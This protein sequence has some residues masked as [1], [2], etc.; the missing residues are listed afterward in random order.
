MEPR[1]RAAPA[2]PLPDAAEIT[3]LYDGDCPLCAREVAL[4]R[5]L[6]RRG[7]LGFEDIAAPSFDAAARGRTQTELMARIHGVLPDGRLVEGMEVF[8]RAYAAVG[9]GWLLAPSRWPGLR[10]LFDVAYRA[11]ARH[12]LR[13]TG[14][15]G[16]P[17]GEACRPLP[18]AGRG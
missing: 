5:R 8:R 15:A 17:C 13:L 18:R 4:L 6:D 10:P 9:L 2:L 16:E 7:R 12:R 11:F 3:L 14:R 1:P